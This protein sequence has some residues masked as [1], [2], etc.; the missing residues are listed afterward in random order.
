VDLISIE[1]SIN[2]TSQHHRLYKY[3]CVLLFVCCSLVASV[4]LFALLVAAT[5]GF[6]RIYAR[7]KYSTREYKYVLR[8]EQLAN[9]RKGGNRQE[10]RTRIVT[11][12]RAF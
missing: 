3:L 7:T 12:E 8:D 4:E 10:E 9:C 1:Y 2:G 5:V 6:E 11:I